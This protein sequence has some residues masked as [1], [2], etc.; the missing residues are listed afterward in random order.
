MPELMRG[1]ECSTET[2]VQSDRALLYALSL[3]AVACASPKHGFY[4]S[5]NIWLLS[6]LNSS[7]LL[8]DSIAHFLYKLASTTNVVNS[9]KPY[10]SKT[11]DSAD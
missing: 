5:P 1:A 6:S 2:Y 8:G 11:S 9:W 10:A 7:N 3:H 4:V